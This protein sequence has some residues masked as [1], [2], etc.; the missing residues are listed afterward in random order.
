[1]AS[2]L[3]GEE[4]VGKSCTLVPE[5]DRPSLE[6]RVTSVGWVWVPC[7]PQ[8]PERDGNALDLRLPVRIECDLPSNLATF[9]PNMRMKVVFEGSENRREA[10]GEEP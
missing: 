2:D 4:L 1:M 8:I 3:T 9:R 10:D 6:G 7:P 5:G